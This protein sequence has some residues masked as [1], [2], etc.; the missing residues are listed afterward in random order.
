VQAS[1]IVTGTLAMYPVP[2]AAGNPVASGSQFFIAFSAVPDSAVPINV[3]G[4][5]IEGL[6]VAQRLIGMDVQPTTNAQGTPEAAPT[7]DVIKT[8]TITEK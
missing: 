1:P 7:A 3:F 8:I 6:D 2:D 4:K 5:V